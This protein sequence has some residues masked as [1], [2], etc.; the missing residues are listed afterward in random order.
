MSFSRRSALLLY[1]FSSESCT[2]YLAYLFS[3]KPFISDESHGS[4]NQRQDLQAVETGEIVGEEAICATDVPRANT[5][6][7][8]REVPEAGSYS[9]VGERAVG[10]LAS[11]PGSLQSHLL[12]QQ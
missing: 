10:A 11:P 7:L 6:K 4:E 9:S 1:I 3:N 5:G 8:C 2:G 12:A